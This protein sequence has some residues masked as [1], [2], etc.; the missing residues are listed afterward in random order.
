MCRNKQQFS[1]KIAIIVQYDTH[2]W[3]VIRQIIERTWA[4]APHVKANIG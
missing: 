3:Q 4:H 1:D 2:V